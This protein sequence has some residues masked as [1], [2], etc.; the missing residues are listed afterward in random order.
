MK[1]KVLKLHW[2]RSKNFGDNLNAYIFSKCFNIEVRYSN[3][4]GANAIGIGS[5]FDR[6]LLQI[7]DIIPFVLSKIILFYP[8]I[9]VFSTGTVGILQNYAQK[10]RFLKSVI[11]KR[12]LK[13]VALRGEKTKAEIEK[14]FNI[15]LDNTVLGDFGLLANK[16]IDEP[17][18]KIYDIGICP[19]YGQK[20]H[21]IIKKMLEET[22]NSV[23]LDTEE[24][25]MVFLR[26]LAQCKTVV[27]TGM[28]PLIAAD[29][30]N[31]PNQWATL[32]GIEKDV[33]RFK[34]PDYYSAL[35]LYEQMP[36]DL[37][38]TKITPEYII[39]NYKVQKQKVIE[40]QNNLLN[41]ISKA[42]DEIFK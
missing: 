23:F 14:H 3:T 26:K 31:I 29:S 19:H 15:K 13:F 2:W 37:R 18:E 11:L 9:Y 35:G 25:L 41:A 34:I 17:I 27:S 30:L 16:L 38:K 8:P 32:Y 42:L 24:D 33:T 6:C 1:K 39:Q 10:G 21:P 28:H 40:V 7:R 4:W 12:K 36:V 5:I 22:P 20:E